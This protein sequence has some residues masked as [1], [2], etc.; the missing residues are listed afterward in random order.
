MTFIYT[1]L[2][3]FLCFSFDLFRMKSNHLNCLLINNYHNVFFQCEE[4][5]VKKATA[6]LYVSSRLYTFSCLCIAKTNIYMHDLKIHTVIYPVITLKGLKH[7]FSSNCLTF[8]MYINV[9]LLSFFSLRLNEF[10][11]PYDKICI[12]Y[13]QSNI[14]INFFLICFNPRSRISTDWTFKPGD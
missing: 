8:L 6:M 5:I 12:Y 3:G 9:N 14:P 7:D 13:R 2:F 11:L 10:K 4:P 1:Q